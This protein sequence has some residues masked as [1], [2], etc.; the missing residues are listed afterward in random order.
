MIPVTVF[1][2]PPLGFGEVKEPS[3][4]NPKKFDMKVL[5]VDDSSKYEKKGKKKKKFK[6][7]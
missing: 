1:S 3:G 4:W 2:E 5:V 6:K 7:E